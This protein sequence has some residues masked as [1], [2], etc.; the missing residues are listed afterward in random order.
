MLNES[1]HFIFQIKHVI[2]S[3]S[4]TSVDTRGKI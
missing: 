4:L 3:S 1:T 2:G